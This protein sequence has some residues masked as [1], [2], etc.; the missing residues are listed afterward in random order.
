MPAP[1]TQA[2]SSPDHT[3]LDIDNIKRSYGNYVALKGVSLGV[4]TGEFI[5]LVGPSGCGKTTLLKLIAG[6]ETA[7]SGSIRIENRDM[8]DV[9]ASQRPTSMVFQK[10]AL[11]PHMTIAQ[12]IGFP[13]KLR[14][15]APSVIAQKVREMLDLMQLKPE[16][17]NRFPKQ[18]S[19]GEQQRVALAR[20]MISSPKLLLLDE[21]LSALD[22]KLKKVLQ[23]ELKRL[24]RQVGVTFVHVTHDLEEAMMLADRICV[25]RAGQI[26]QIGR[27]ND[28][29]YRPADAFVAGFIGDTN[30]LPI[31]VRQ[32]DS[33]GI[34]FAGADFSGLQHLSADRLSPA[35]QTGEGLLMVR[36]ELLTLLAPGT[37]A[38]GEIA[39]EV[40]EMFGKGGTIQYRARSAAGSDLV[41][42]IPGTDQAP[43][44]VGA[45]IRLGWRWQD[46]FAMPLTA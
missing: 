30:L 17:L 45:Q 23:A 21:P 12:N 9:P 20:S 35:L 40:T 29:Y 1:S 8:T 44:D 25:M 42:E 41:F 26:L 13:L 46:A 28:I 22:V 3:I 18:L 15:V 37:H 33:D 4:E 6:F 14:G 2:L 19:G 38:D 27:P 34:R 43:V 7:Q 11:F 31:D 32:I 24:H 10:L 36:P 5:A 16:Y 39:A